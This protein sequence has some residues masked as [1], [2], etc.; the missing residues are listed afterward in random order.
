MLQNIERTRGAYL[1]EIQLFYNE[2]G[3]DYVNKY[4]SKVELMEYFNNEVKSGDKVKF[5][6]AFCYEQN[7]LLASLGS[8]DQ[9]GHIVAL[10][11]DK[12][13]G[14]NLFRVIDFTH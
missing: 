10:K 1:H 9:L 7:N 4:D 3:I 8:G 2:I 6:L 14:R 5:A 11:F 13:K 12:S